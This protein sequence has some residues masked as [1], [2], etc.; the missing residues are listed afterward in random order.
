M[1]KAKHITT[2]AKV[3]HPYELM[4]DEV[5]F[6]YRLPNLNAALGCAQMKSLKGFIKR[7]RNLASE[8][9][10]F[11]KNTDFE[12]ICEPTYG[13]SNYWLNAIICPNKRSRDIM[14]KETRR[15]NISTRPVWMPINKLP[16]FKNSIK[17]KL[18]VTEFL[19]E[20]IVNIPS[21]PT[22]L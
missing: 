6:N 3:A 12:F 1:K 22:Q 15:A 17:S 21:S 14:L 7:K 16:M 10:R 20:R 19:W 5:A 13:K 9:K 18:T 2:T 11:F 8:Y 4:H